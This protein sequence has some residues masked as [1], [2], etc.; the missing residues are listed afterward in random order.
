LLIKKWQ[1][2][3]KYY[4]A[5]QTP[6]ILSLGGS[7]DNLFYFELWRGYDR[8][9]L[10]SHNQAQETLAVI[11]TAIN[12]TT[13]LTDVYRLGLYIRRNSVRTYL[14]FVFN[15]D[16]RLIKVENLANISYGY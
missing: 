12:F 3:T 2:A 13:I 5:I 1:P 14:N 8:F 10:S 11:N 15:L 9:I 6:T 16:S 7:D 4:L